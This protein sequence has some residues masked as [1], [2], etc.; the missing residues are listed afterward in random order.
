M[1]ICN[2]WSKSLGIRTFAPVRIWIDAIYE[3]ILRV[4]ELKW[5]MCNR[6][7]WTTERGVW[8]K[9]NCECI[10]YVYEYNLHTNDCC[11]FMSRSIAWM[12]W[13]VYMCKRKDMNETTQCMNT[14]EMWI[15]SM[16]CMCNNSAWRK[17]LCIWVKRMYERKVCV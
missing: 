11:M 13:I 8:V 5:Y 16:K 10:K 1:N 14:Y 17:I 15:K 4:I 9:I 12:N 6:L 7:V 2:L 3:Y